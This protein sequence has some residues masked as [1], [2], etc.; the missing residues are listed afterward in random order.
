MYIIYLPL[1][2]LKRTTTPVER[3]TYVE[4]FEQEW[5]GTYRELNI[6]WFENGII[7]ASGEDN[8]CLEFNSIQTNLP[9]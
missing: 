1:Q 8:F 5:K 6:V 2:T 7:G 4:Q 9:G 3:C